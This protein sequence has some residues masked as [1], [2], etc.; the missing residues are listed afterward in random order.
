M[1]KCG[2]RV[3]DVT[4][5]W[6]GEIRSTG[7]CVDGEWGLR[8]HM[9]PPDGL[10]SEAMVCAAPCWAD[11]GSSSWS[12]KEEVLLRVPAEAPLCPNSTVCGLK[13]L[14][15]S[16]RYTGQRRS[17]AGPSGGTV[18]LQEGFDGE[19]TAELH[20]TFDLNGSAACSFRRAES[21]AALWWSDGCFHF[22]GQLREELQDSFEVATH[23]FYCDLTQVQFPVVSLTVQWIWS[24][25]N[26]KNTTQSF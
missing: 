12:L 10:S 15:R 5:V 24:H 22:A 18:S 1:G 2:H 11:G 25:W 8:V 19:R 4:A 23:H 14:L 7:S 9:H 6:A 17:S 3:S 13:L 20:L 16:H 21:W 26:L